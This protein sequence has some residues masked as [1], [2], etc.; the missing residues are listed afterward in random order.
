MGL[1]DQAGQSA[2]NQAEKAEK[3]AE[4][5]E[6]K[7][8]EQMVQWIIDKTG[9]E[10]EFQGFATLAVLAY[11][12]DDPFATERRYPTFQ[13]DDVLVA[14]ERVQGTTLH[15]VMTSEQGWYLGPRIVT[16]ISTN[17]TKEER[18]EK[19]VEGIGRAINAEVDHPVDLLRANAKTCPTCG[20]SW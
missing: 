9:Y 6:E 18:Q 1:A 10:P 16:A 11:L 19:L 5:A 4:A 2:K 20:R 3:A 17:R 12:G 13:I 14:I 7:W 15:L 8:V